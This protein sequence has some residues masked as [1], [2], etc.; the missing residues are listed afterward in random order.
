VAKAGENP[1]EFRISAYRFG[2]E[3]SVASGNVSPG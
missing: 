1:A 3:A 2:E